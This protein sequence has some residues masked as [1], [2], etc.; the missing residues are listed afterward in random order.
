MKISRISI[1]FMI[2]MLIS[3]NALA[4]RRRTSRNLDDDAGKATEDNSTE[5]L[6][7]QSEED[8]NKK[9]KDFQQAKAKKSSAI[10]DEL[11]EADI[12][13]FL[14]E[15]IKLKNSLDTIT[16]KYGEVSTQRA[17]ALHKLG[18]VVYKLK[19]FEDAL[20]I[21]KEIVTIYEQVYGYE[22]I[23]TSEALGNLASASFR[24]QLHDHCAL[25]M[26]RALHIIIKKFGEDSKEV[27]LHR[28]KML[29][30]NISDGE[31]SEG[32]DYESAMEKYDHLKNEL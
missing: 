2:A 17:D 15:E 20:A 16:A 5:T 23:K 24:L 13:K 29:T 9:L 6:N 14:G 21:S 4:R 12:Y 3:K 7:Y 22:H 19:K 10:G 27:L 18:R 26:Y 11:S 25:A 1:L 31:T 32:L 8:L 28:A 30:F